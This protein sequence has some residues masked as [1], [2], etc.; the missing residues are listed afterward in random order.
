[1]GEG[2]HNEALAAMNGGRQEWRC[3]RGVYDLNALKAIRNKGKLTSRMCSSC[4]SRSSFL[5][6]VVMRP[7]KQGTFIDPNRI[8][9]INM[10][11]YFT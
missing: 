8:P 2:V 6:V 7:G 4:C 11:D 10:S 5:D 3:S 9:S 1:M